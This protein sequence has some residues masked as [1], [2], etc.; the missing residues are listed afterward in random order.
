ME[1]HD[2]GS[3]KRITDIIV[4][5]QHVADISQETIRQGV[6]EKVILPILGK[7]YFDTGIRILVNPTGRF[8]VGGPQGDVGLTGRKIIVDTYGGVIPHGGGAFSGK[9]ATKLDR[10]GAYMARYACKN[11]V[12]AGL[13]DRCQLSV[14][15]AI[16]VV[17]PVSFHLETFG[18]EKIPIEVIYGTLRSIFDFTPQGI[19]T[20][21]G[22]RMPIYSHTAS[23]GHFKT[24]ASWENLDKVA[25]LKELRTLLQ[26]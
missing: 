2:D 22:L 12:A 20:T 26:L 17:E 24:G 25:I 23:Y 13:A 11:I 5:T 1:Y 8:V 9:D 15:Y 4:S 14:S 19:I 16:G 7:N 21:L 3:F 6:I 10:S 18:T